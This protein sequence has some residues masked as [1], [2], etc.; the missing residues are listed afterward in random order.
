MPMKSKVKNLCIFVLASC[1]VFLSVA[2]SS[3]AAE[4]M[5]V[6]MVQ[7]IATPSKYHEKLV[8]VVAFFGEGSA[9]YLHKED[10]AALR[11]L[12]ANGI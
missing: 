11:Y 8:R 12:R 7:L 1:C 10:Y 2:S 9:L 3:H 6:S 5:T 4:P